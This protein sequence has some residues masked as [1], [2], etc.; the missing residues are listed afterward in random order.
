MNRCVAVFDVGKTN[1]KVVVFDARGAGRRRALRAQR[2]ARRLTRN[3]PI[4]GSTR[5][6]PGLSSSARSRNSARAFPSRRS[7]SPRTARRRPCYGRRPEALPP[8]DYEFDGL[9]RCRRRTMTRCGRRSR[10]RESPHLPRGLNLGQ[11]HFLLT[12]AAIRQSSQPRDAFLSYPQYFGL[13]PERRRWLR[14]STSLGAHTDLWRPYEGGLSSMVDKLGW[15]RLFPPM[16]KA[17]DTLG[18]LKPEVAAATGL[19]AGCAHH[20]RRARFE[21][22]SRARIS[23]PGAIRSP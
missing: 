6:A 4:S 16:R 12:S 22:L 8:L 1:I 15:R 9:R 14:K 3:G 11:P 19:V 20:L 13:A 21:R 17:W 10:R 5:K 7:R 18:T 2:A 23:Y